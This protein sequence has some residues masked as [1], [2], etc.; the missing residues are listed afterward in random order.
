MLR[1]ARLLNLLPRLATMLLLLQIPMRSGRSRS[2]S[3]NADH[4]RMPLVAATPVSAE[5][6]QTQDAVVVAQAP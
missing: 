6:V 2:M 1:I 5:G 4:D 3:K